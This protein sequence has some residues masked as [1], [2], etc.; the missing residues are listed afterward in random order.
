M[1][2]IFSA[3]GPDDMPAHIKSA[4]IGAS[5]TIPIK[6]GKLVSTNQHSLR[7]ETADIFIG[8]WNMARNLVSRV[9]RSPPS[10]TSRRNYPGGKG[11]RKIYSGN[12]H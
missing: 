3:E 7:L 11:L 6:D 9:P 10:A 8:Y 2:T 5:V 1:L 12:T 4:L